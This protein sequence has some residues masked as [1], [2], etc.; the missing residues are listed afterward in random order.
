[1]TLR[2]ILKSYNKEKINSFS[3]ILYNLLIN[4]K[5]DVKGVVSLP[6]KIKK[7]CVLRSPHVNKDSREQFEIRIYKKIIDIKT[8]LPNVLKQLLKIKT[9][10]EI[11][12]KLEI[13]KNII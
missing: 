7:F 13:K 4:E 9:P 5:C 12:S 1:M 3:K 8:I 10:A 2:I 11:A 6:T